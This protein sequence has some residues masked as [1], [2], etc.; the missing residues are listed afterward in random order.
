MSEDI[1]LYTTDNKVQMYSTEDEVNSKLVAILG[2]KFKKYRENFTAASNFQLETDF[3]LYLNIELHQICNLKCPMCSIGDPNANEKYVTDQKMSWET[4]EKIILEGEKYGCPSV[5]PQGTNEPLLSP[6]LEKY[7]KFA[8][9]HGFI[10][11]MLNSN[12]TLLTE[13][14]ARKLLRSGLTRIRFSLDAVTEDTYKKIR[15]GGTFDRVLEN[16]ERFLKIRKSEW[17]FQ[18]MVLI[19]TTHHDHL[20]QRPIKFPTTD[21]TNIIQLEHVIQ[22]FQKP[23]QIRLRFCQSHD[24]L[25]MGNEWQW[26]WRSELQFVIRSRDCH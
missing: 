13:D 11:I 14:R 23:Y 9:E 12:A 22:L 19:T 4:Y 8:S 7:I 5:C 25:V 3:P 21:R 20:A 17:K 15:I 26:V 2:D 6:D 16:I 18:Y 24:G 10:D 1:Y